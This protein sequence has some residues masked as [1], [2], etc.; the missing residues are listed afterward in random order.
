MTQQYWLVTIQVSNTCT[1]IVFVTF[2]GLLLIT[3]MIILSVLSK[4]TEEYFFCHMQLSFLFNHVGV[5]FNHNSSQNTL[6]NAGL[7][8]GTIHKQLR[9]KM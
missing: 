4:V 5:N 3:Y 6:K 1:H 8:A 9:Q 2:I 7:R